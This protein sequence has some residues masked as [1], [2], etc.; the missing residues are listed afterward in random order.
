MYDN[1]SKSNDNVTFVKHA[2]RTFEM[3]STSVTSGALIPVKALF[4]SGNFLADNISRLRPTAAKKEAPEEEQRSMEFIQLAQIVADQFVYYGSLSHSQENPDS[5]EDEETTAIE[6]ALANAIDSLFSKSHRCTLTEIASLETSSQHPESTEQLSIQ[7]LRKS[8]HNKAAQFPVEKPSASVKL[9]QPPDVLVK[10]GE[11]L[12]DISS[13]ALKFWKE[14]GLRPVDGP[15]NVTAFCLC[16]DIPMLRRGAK[17]LLEAVG[18]TY[19][20]LRLGTHFAGH[21]I[22][23]DYASGL[24]TFSADENASRRVETMGMICEQFGIPI[25][26]FS[27]H[28]LTA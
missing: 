5:E 15:K 3:R 24:V 9:L 21:D 22:L 23:K 17:M 1:S 2:Q 7:T 11:T 18:Q 12:I 8:E 20:S 25:T 16:P 6:K 19:M 4:E 28:S 14:L 26:L 27:K 10:R 13:T